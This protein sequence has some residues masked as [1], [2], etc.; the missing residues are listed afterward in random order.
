MPA[1]FLT[2]EPA[3][4]KAFRLTH[5]CATLPFVNV[6]V[7]P[8]GELKL[9]AIVAAAG[10]D[11]TSSV[12]PPAIVGM[13]LPRVIAPPLPAPQAI[14]LTPPALFESMT[15]WRRLP[16]PASSVFVT[17]KTAAAAGAA[18]SSSAASDD[19]SGLIPSLPARAAP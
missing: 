12:V 5:G 18:A 14:V 3:P 15:A 17:L 19:G 10:A 8:S 2:R 13:S 6:T 16:A 11:E 9:L 4:G 1:P 7:P